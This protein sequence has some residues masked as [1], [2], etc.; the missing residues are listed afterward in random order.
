MIILNSMA[1]FFLTWVSYLPTF[2]SK[3]KL[4][5][6]SFSSPFFYG[7]RTF[8][9]YIVLFFLQYSTVPTVLQ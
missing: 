6:S 5:T 1:N 4:V 3:K 7:L 8:S 2:P 9:L